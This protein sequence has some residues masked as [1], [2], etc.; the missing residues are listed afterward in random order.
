[1]KRLADAGN[2]EQAAEV[3]ARGGPR[4]RARAK[5]RRFAPVTG[6]GAGGRRSATSCG[7]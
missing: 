5:A 3:R 1:M 6:R 7:A 2:Y 4:T